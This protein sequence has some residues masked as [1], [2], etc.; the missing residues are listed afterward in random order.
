MDR[1]DP[2]F[3]LQSVAVVLQPQGRGDIAPIPA[4]MMR[5]YDRNVVLGQLGLGKSSDFQAFHGSCDG[6]NL[7]VRLSK[8]R[9]I[10][11]F[12]FAHG[13]QEGLK[14]P[15]EF[16]AVLLTLQTVPE[17][18]L[19]PVCP[20]GMVQQLRFDPK[21]PYLVSHRHTSFSSSRLRVQF[22]A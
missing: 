10:A 9:H 19:Y 3:A 18:L 7:L 20:V 14:L 6:K 2:S 12:L 17:A 8:Q 13:I 15:F 21:R 11:S 4:L 1:K 22:L 16:S 5:G